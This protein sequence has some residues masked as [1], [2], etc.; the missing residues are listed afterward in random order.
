MRAMNCQA[1]KMPERETKPQNSTETALFYTACYGFVLYSSIN[2]KQISKMKTYQ[3]NVETIEAGQRKSYG[4]SFY[5]YKVT[6]TENEWDVKNFCTKVLKSSCEKKDM[7]DPFAGELLEFK[8]ITNNN[9]GK[10]FSE[11]KESE[12]FSYKVRI[13]YA[14]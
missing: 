14:G 13:E 4:D 9:D 2:L 7:P 12:I 1:D 8:K 3:F 6:S 5:S 11:A 10:L